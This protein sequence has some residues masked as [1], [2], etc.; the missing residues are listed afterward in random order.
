[1]LGEEEAP[2]LITALLR[3][4]AGS[5]VIWDFDGVVGHTEPLH[6]ASYRELAER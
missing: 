1:M 4:A 3:K 2:S 5:R 6:E